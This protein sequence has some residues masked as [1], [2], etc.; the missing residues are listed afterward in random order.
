MSV[1]DTSPEL[2]SAVALWLTI[3]P[4]RRFDIAG[5]TVRAT[6]LTLIAQGDPDLAEALR[7]HAAARPYTVSIMHEERVPA[8]VALRVTS[9]GADIP[10]ALAAA[11][12]RPRERPLVMLGPSA[13]TALELTTSPLRTPWVNSSS[14]YELQRE[15]ALLGDTITFILASPLLP[16]ER[17]VSWKL[18][19]PSGATLSPALLFSALR[20][21]WLAFGNRA[22][23]PGSREVQLAATQAEILDA[24]L[25]ITTHLRRGGSAA[26]R[27]ELRGFTGRIT[28]RLGGSPAQRALLRTLA[29]ACFYLGAGVGTATGMGRIRAIAGDMALQTEVASS[30]RFV[31]AWR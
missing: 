28:L 26:A 22:L 18:G 19:P 12:A 23:P 4:D 24:Q 17:P 5:A 2:L 29:A 27:E 13:V 14:L 10:R 6:V 20:E 3:R 1:A 21:R 31:A 16:R 15:A 8:Q 25:A 9:I 7:E 30:R 11:V